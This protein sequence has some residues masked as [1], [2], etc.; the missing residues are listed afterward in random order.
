MELM[1][2]V[3]GCG[4]LS[5]GN[6]FYLSVELARFSLFLLLLQGFYFSTWNSQLRKIKVH[7]KSFW[8]DT[9]QPVKESWLKYDIEEI[10]L[11]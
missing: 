6:E 1:S 5:K 9:T 2:P 3:A 8:K 4:T 11:S 10:F 7:T